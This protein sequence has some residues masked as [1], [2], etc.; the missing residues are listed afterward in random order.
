MCPTA[1]P[2]TNKVFRRLL[3]IPVPIFDR[4]GGVG[5]QSIFRLTGK[6]ADLDTRKLQ[7]RFN[8]QSRSAVW[9]RLSAAC[10]P[11]YSSGSPVG[12][13]AG[14]DVW[15]G[16]KVPLYLIAGEADTITPVANV[17][18]IAKF[19]GRDIGTSK[20]HTRPRRIMS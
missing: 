2:P 12:G 9:M 16:V 3:P 4:R 1:E 15:A 10:L 11:D 17:T 20:S 18:K 19:V 5:S 8:E 7:L 13:V 14:K 6:D